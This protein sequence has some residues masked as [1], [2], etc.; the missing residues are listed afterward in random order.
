VQVRDGEAAER[1]LVVMKNLTHHGDNLYPLLGSIDGRATAAGQVHQGRYRAFR[2]AFQ[3][4]L[5]PVQDGLFTAAQQLSRLGDGSTLIGPQDD[6]NPDHQPG[7]FTTFFLRSAQLSLLFAAELD[8]VFVRFVSDGT[9]TSFLGM[10]S[11]Y[12]KNFWNA[13]LVEISPNSVAGFAAL[14]NRRPLD[15]A[16]GLMTLKKK[17]DKR[18][19]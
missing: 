1:L 4:S 8:S 10:A 7:I 9:E 19:E 3:K 18:Y 13:P 17:G 14:E 5:A 12:P 6:Q 2:P 15:D 11:V 16:V